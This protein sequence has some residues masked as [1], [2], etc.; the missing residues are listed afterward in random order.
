MLAWESAEITNAEGVSM[1][2]SLK[3]SDTSANVQIHQNTCFIEDPEFAA[4]VCVGV[5]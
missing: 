5:R 4:N 2:P 3:V 1:M